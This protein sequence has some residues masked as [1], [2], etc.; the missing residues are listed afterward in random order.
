MEFFRADIPGKLTSQKS[1]QK[2]VKNPGKVNKI[3]TQSPY[4]GTMLASVF[5]NI[6]T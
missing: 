4:P 5:P 6:L 2:K 3:K 1:V